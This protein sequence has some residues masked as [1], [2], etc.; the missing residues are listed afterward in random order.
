M[1]LFDNTMISTYRR[2]PREF[3]YRHRRH[4][5]PEGIALPLAFGLGWHEAM[6]VVWGLASSAKSDLELRQMAFEAFLNTWTEHGCPHPDDILLDLEEAMAPRTPGT[7]L[8]MIAAYITQR[9][10]RIAAFNILDIERPFAVPIYPSRSDILYVGRRDK[11][12]ELP[13]GSVI[14]GEH[15]TTSLYAKKSGFRSEFLDMFSPNSQVDGYLHSSYMEYGNRLAAVWIDAALVHKNVHDAFK[16]IPVDRSISLLDGW[17]LETRLWIERIEGEDE[18][19]LN[20]VPSQRIIG[21]FPKNTDSCHRYGKPCPYKD[22]C[23]AKADPHHIEETPPGFVHDEW[24][25]FD[26]LELNKLGLEQS[27]EKSANA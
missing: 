9:R 10:P 5:R 12:F 22:L 4:W 19:L 23:R 17:L 8:A 25:P 11:I 21:S 20:Q 7:A 6:D 27:K 13:D 14:V 26:I 16:F 24:S 18:A 3:Y 1:K 2:C 15:K